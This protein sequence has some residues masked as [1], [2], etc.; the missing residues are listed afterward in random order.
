LLTGTT[1]P[2]FFSHIIPTHQQCFT[3][4]WMGLDNEAIVVVVV[5]FIYHFTKLFT[6]LTVYRSLTVASKFVSDVFYANAR[7][8]KVSVE[9]M[10]VTDMMLLDGQSYRV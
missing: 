8:A 6:K 7:Y 5:V 1:W 9:C 3:N 2:P 4:P 10:S